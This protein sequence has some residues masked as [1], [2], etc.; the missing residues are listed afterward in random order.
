[1]HTDIVVAFTKKTMSP[2]NE[3]ALNQKSRM[4]MVCMMSSQILGGLLSTVDCNV[5]RNDEDDVV[6]KVA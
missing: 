5:V 6:F 4:V 1:M 3:L 2:W